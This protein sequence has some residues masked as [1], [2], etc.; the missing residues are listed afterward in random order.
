MT[1]LNGKY[2]NESNHKKGKKFFIKAGIIADVIGVVLIIVGIILIVKGTSVTKVD[3]GDSGWADSKMASMGF[4]MGGSMLSFL[5][6]ASIM[7][8]IGMYVS[9]HR[10]EIMA[11]S[12]STVLPVVKEGVEYIAPTVG[13]VVEEIASGVSDGIRETKVEYKCRKCGASV[14]KRHKYCPNCGEILKQ[15]KTCKNCG[16]KLESSTKFCPDC[17]TEVE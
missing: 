4:F 12:A 2:V 1:E 15:E 5:G 8:S 3:M 14:T 7:F 10:R 16:S 9:A 6:L 11:Y 13:N 17:G